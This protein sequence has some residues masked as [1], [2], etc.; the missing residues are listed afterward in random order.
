MIT[1]IDH[2]GIAVK[3]LEASNPCEKALSLS[4]EGKEEVATKVRTAF[5]NIN[6]VHIEL[7]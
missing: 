7:C 3:S 4:C 6:G 5:F 2:L 1:G